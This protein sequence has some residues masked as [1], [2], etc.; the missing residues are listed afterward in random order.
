MAAG[1][2]PVGGR[3]HVFEKLASILGLVAAPLM[4]LGLSACGRSAGKTSEPTCPTEPIDA[5]DSSTTPDPSCV[6]RATEINGNGSRIQTWTGSYDAAATQ[7]GGVCVVAPATS[8][9]QCGSRSTK[10]RSRAASI[11]S[12]KRRW[13]LSQHAP[14]RH[15]WHHDDDAVTIA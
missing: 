5:A 6:V 11:R 10:A 12:I 13:L 2:M 9:P 14:L 15:L 1:T 7:S 4:L 8:T 3:Q